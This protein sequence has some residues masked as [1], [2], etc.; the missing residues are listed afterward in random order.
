M[1]ANWNKP[2][3]NTFPPYYGK[4]IALVGD[5]DL[6][7]ILDQ[8]MQDLTDFLQ[9]I[10]ENI[11]DHRYAEGKWT[12]RQVLQHMIDG[13]RVFSYRLM[14][15]ARG[16]QTPLPGYE[17]NDY[18]R[19][20]NVEERSFAEQIAEFNAVRRS[21]IALVMSLND[22]LLDRMG[23]ANGNPISVRAIAYIMA[24][25]VAHHRNILQERYL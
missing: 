19:E 17:E 3:E 7:H 14:C 1:V 8:Q 2:A 13:E 15:F 9:N 22:A 16:E 24:G 18:A 4:Y 23:N 5:G 10:P 6:T 21:T 11:Y 12:P 20:A 25:H